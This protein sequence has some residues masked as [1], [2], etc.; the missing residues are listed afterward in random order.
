MRQTSWVRGWGPGEGER[1]GEIECIRFLI[2]GKAGIVE[3]YIS[4]YNT[5]IITR[6]K[7]MQMEKLPVNELFE[8]QKNLLTEEIKYIHSIITDY[9]DLSFKI[10]G[11][12]VTI[13]SAVVAF[14]AKENAPLVII[15]SIP[16]L[17]AFWILDAYFKQYQ[18]RSM[19]R[20]SVIEDF[21]NSKYDFENNGLKKA[22]EMKDFGQ[23]PIHDPIAG[24]SRKINQNIEKRYKENT[25]LSRCFKVPN[26][27]YFYLILSISAILIVFLLQIFS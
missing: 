1:I 14:G 21:L 25:K 13:W 3:K 23:F 26:V 2:T 11:W 6:K 20:I 4:V 27:S 18:R 9:D 16:V 24:S 7:G 5:S 10:K 8:F 12:A 15:A 22:F 19:S 17:I